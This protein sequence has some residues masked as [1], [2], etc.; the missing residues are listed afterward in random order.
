MR[1]FNCKSKTEKLFCSNHIRN[2][3]STGI[4][5]NAARN[6]STYTPVHF[7]ALDPIHCLS[8]DPDAA[9]PADHVPP[10]IP[11]HSLRL[12]R[13]ERPSNLLHVVLVHFIETPH[14]N[15]LTTATT[16]PGGDYLIVGDDRG[17]I[18]VCATCSE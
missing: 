5:I 15:T 18:E 4:Y 1:I 11:T 17:Q 12:M 6:T 14:N 3:L 16:S 2:P 13:R 7:L 8:M 9:N 10:I